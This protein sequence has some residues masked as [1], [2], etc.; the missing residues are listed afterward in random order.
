MKK[1]AGRFTIENG[2]LEGP[3]NYMTEKGNAKLDGILAG[4]DAAFNVMVQVAPNPDPEMLVLV[5]LQT[6]YAGWVGMKQVQGWFGK[7]AAGLNSVLS[8]RA[9]RRPR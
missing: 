1:T 9:A 8:R 4:T 7:P 2:V 6:D 3:G 5:A